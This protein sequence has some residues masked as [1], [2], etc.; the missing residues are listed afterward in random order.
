MLSCVPG[1]GWLP[2]LLSS[3]LSAQPRSSGGK[4]NRTAGPSG[5]RTGSGAAELRITRVFSCVARGFKARASF[6]FAGCCWWRSLAV[7]G[8]SGT[9]RGHESVMGRPGSRWDGAVERPSAFQAGR[10]P[11]C[12]GSC[13]C[14]ALSLAADVSGW[15]LLLLSPLLS[16]RKL[17]V[18]AAVLADGRLPDEVRAEPRG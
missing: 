15:L 5:P 3:L 16:G 13:E 12:D 8:S 2:T 18:A 9:S 10:I 17:G 4:P 1:G 7:D 14:Y 11:R 6:M